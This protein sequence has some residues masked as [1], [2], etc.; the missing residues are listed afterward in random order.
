M[1]W[2]QHRLHLRPLVSLPFF[3]SSPRVQHLHQSR[4]DNANNAQ[5]FKDHLN[6]VRDLAKGRPI[7]ITE[8]GAV[9]TDDEIKGF[10][11]EVIPWM[12]DSGD[13]HRYAY[14]MA[15]EGLLINSQGNDMSEI[16]RHFT[17]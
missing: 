13:I 9:G 6:K 17:Y 4:Y 7:W 8:M 3:R 12:D 2:L 10:L 1:R 16:G 14:F 15:R 11:N 5:Y